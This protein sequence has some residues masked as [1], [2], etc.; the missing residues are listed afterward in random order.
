MR[1]PWPSRGLPLPSSCSLHGAP[2]ICLCS[3]RLSG[4]LGYCL[5]LTRYG[6]TPVALLGKVLM[7]RRMS[8]ST[9][10]HVAPGHASRHFR[11]HLLMVAIILSAYPFALGFWAVM[12][13]CCM[14]E[15]LQYR[16]N[17][18][19]HSDALS[20][21]TTKGVLYLHHFIIQPCS[22]VQ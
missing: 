3:A 18:S 8:G 22:R 5:K 15:N 4:T 16:L 20:S 1:S 7:L 6:C 17:F 9:S 10:Y 19:L 14:P 2:N 12:Y 21:L 11:R 13:F